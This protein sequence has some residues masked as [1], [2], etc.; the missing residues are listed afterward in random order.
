M[1]KLEKTVLKKAGI[2][3]AV[4]AAGVLAVAPLAFAG[5]K[6]GDW[7][8][9]HGTSSSNSKTVSK[10][11]TKSTSPSCTFANVSDSSSSNNASGVAAPLLGIL[12]TAANATA[13]I[14]AGTNA[15]IASCNNFSDLIDLNSNNKTKT[16][17]NSK[18]IN[19]SKNIN[20]ASTSNTSI[21]TSLTGLLG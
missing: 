16:V 8:H 3:V 1:S 2:I 6:G 9:G 13:P 12:G 7:N 21:L 5:D 11:T 19:N 4:T 18:D 17:D 20:K 10:T 15:P 14:T